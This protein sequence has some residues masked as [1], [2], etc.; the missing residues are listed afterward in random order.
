[1]RAIF[2][3]LISALSICVLF[4]GFNQKKENY[5]RLPIHQGKCINVINL[6]I[7]KEK[8]DSLTAYRF[9]KKNYLLIKDDGYVKCNVR[10]NNLYKYFSS[11]EK[12]DTRCISKVKLYYNKF[13]KR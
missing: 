12:R 11:S 7:E 10:D 9:F 2:I 13:D 5:E 1:M 4:T 6:L 8:G 3:S